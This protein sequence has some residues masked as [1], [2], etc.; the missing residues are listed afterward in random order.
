MGYDLNPKNKKIES[1]SVGAF[2]WPILLQ[3]TGMGYILWYGTGFKSG[4]YVY[5]NGN[6]GSPVS[7]DGYKV[8]A[9]Q[10]KMMAAIARGYVFVQ[11]HVNQE[12]DALS[13]ED[14]EYWEKSQY[15][16]KKMHEDHLIFLEKFADFAEKSG[17]FSIH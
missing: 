10:A 14:F 3:E 12:W 11:R 6:N 8:T 9:N 16:R 4:T 15:V 5:Q 7:N 2:R 13:P 1:I 17:G